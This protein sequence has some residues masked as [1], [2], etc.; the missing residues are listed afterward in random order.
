M[1][2][3][4]ENLGPGV[5]GPPEAGKPV[6]PAP[7]DRRHHGNRFH[8]VHRGGRAIQA[9]PRREGRLHARHALFAFQAFQQ[10]RFLAT[11]IG[12]G[13]VVQVQIIVPAGP[14]GILAQQARVIAFVQ[15][16]LQGFALADVFAPDVDVAGI[17]PHREPGNQTAL[18]Q[19]MRIVPH[20]LAVLAGAGFGFVGIDHQIGRASVGH[21][22]HER[23]F[24]AGG[25]ARPAAPAQPAGLDLIDD[26]VAPLR[27]EAGGP[28]PLPP[29]LRPR[30]AAVMHPVKVGEDAVLILQHRV[31]LN[32][33]GARARSGRS[34][35]APRRTQPGRQGRTEKQNGRPSQT[36]RQ[37]AAPPS[38][39][40]S[41]PQ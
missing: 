39:T 5:V 13:P 22:G 27:Q 34:R 19:R 20:D 12:P 11:D 25:K 9:G 28:V 4:A 35:P 18:D 40:P 41:L 1:P 38:T 24:Q 16:R 37:A 3:N 7:Q 6:R 31:V 30:Q 8:I 17:G 32:C 29:L 33:S 26:P 15:R 23:P 10:R 14:G 2:R 21:L 36:F